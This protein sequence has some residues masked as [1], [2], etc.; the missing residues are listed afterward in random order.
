M[1]VVKHL[2]VQAQIAENVLTLMIPRQETPPNV[3]EM[4]I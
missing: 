3:Q 4:K 1:L 2:K